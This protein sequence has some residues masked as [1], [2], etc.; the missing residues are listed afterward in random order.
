MDSPARSRSIRT[1]FVFALVVLVLSYQFAQVRFAA[2]QF[3][4]FATPEM[5]AAGTAWLPFQFR[6]LVPWLAGWL[7][8]LPLRSGPSV[9]GWYKIIELVSTVALCYATRHYLSLFIPDDRLTALWTGAL[10]YVL[11]FNLTFTFWYPW[12]VPSL[13]FFTLGLILLYRRDWKW[14]YPLF[15][16]ATL[17][18]ETTALL[19]L[20]YLATTVGRA[21][22]RQW[23]GHAA[24][25]AALWLALRLLLFALYGRNPR[26]GYGL[27]EL[28]LFNNLDW[29]LQPGIVLALLRN[30]GLIW[31]PVVLWPRFVSDP[32]VHRALL[33]VPLMMFGLGFVGVVHELRIYSE[34]VPLLL[35]ALALVVQ[36]LYQSR[37]GAPPSESLP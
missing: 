11:P 26:L 7:G 29:L 16:L 9:L 24:L 33:I 5:L 22:R 20:V 6:P 31:V 8:S 12:D 19:T 37:R 1:N 35:P 36:G 25:Q 17:N 23:L 18:R 13:L 30:W 10:F 3:Y 14:Y 2:N 34:A 4:G 28:K 32:F 27:F 15:A 21:P